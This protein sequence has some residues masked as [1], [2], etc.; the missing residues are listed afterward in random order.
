MK[1]LLLLFICLTLS[2]ACLAFSAS[3]VYQDVPLND[4][5]A[6][7]VEKA[8]QYGLVNGYGNALFG[9]RDPITRAQFV[10]ILSRMFQWE[11]NDVSTEILS[12]LQ[13]ESISAVYLPAIKTAAFLDVIEQN[14]PFRGNDSITRKEMA[15]ML[16]RALGLKSAAMHAE[17][18]S[19][20][21]FI[22]V[23]DGSG[24][25]SVAYDI[26]MTKGTSATTFS[27]DNTATR[28]QAAAMLVR[29]YEKLHPKEDPWIHSHYA[30]SSYSQI[31]LAQE[32]DAVTLGWSRMQWDG[33]NTTLLTTSKNQNEYYIP[34]GYET[35]VKSLDGS[36][37][38]LHLGVYM[39]RNAGELLSS[40]K[41]RSDAVAA[42]IN[43]VTVKY[44]TLKRNPYSGVT[45]DFE[46]LRSTHRE[47][48]T[49]FLRELSV[50]LKKLQ[51]TLYV[52]VSPVLE[53]GIYYDGY[54]Y[55]EI[56]NLADKVILMAYDYDAKD[57]AGFIG[58]NYYK[59]AASAPIDQVYLAL[60]AISD[61]DFGVSDLSKIVLGCSS[62]N[63]AWNI[64]ESGKLLSEN[65]VYPNNDTVIKRMKTTAENWSSS[66]GTPYLEY[67]T[68]TGD[69]YFLWYEN[70]RSIQLK[71]D[72]AK[73]FGINAISFWR[74]GTI[75]HYTEWNWIIS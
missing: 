17:K 33:E 23:T 69:H 27:P 61:P 64:S 35:V 54:A 19:K 68:E 12:D 43:E 31:D 16:V 21:P 74:L 56:G 24:Y 5:L 44:K 52:C 53:T 47:N 62:K 36:G 41:S 26:G 1:R 22:D 3:A 25:I 13:I 34:N 29:I 70:N 63:I 46:G 40:E 18:N 51:Q 67:Q 39:D 28:G 73:L 71:L 7:E 20:L 2:A 45:I 42:I 14:K 9:F 75:P 59:T 49:D 4:V 32:S 50:E 48:F 66:Y 11:F 10:T 57:L 37:V 58:S 15:E 65:P 30:I 8:T 60:K 55:R 38:K 72:T 6:S